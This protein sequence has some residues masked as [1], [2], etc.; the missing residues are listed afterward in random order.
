MHISSALADCGERLWTCDNGDCIPINKRCDGSVDCSDHSDEIAENCIHMASDCLPFGF[1]C[2][3]GACIAG[4]GRCDNNTDC[5]DKSDEYACMNENPEH[6]RGNCRSNQMQCLT[7]KECIG[8]NDMC[9]GVKNCRDG[10]DETVEVCAG[11]D[12]SSGFQ[13]GYGG[14][15]ADYAKCNK[16]RECVDGSDEAWELCGT[17]RKP[18]ISVGVKTI[19]FPDSTAIGNGGQRCRIPFDL[20]SVI[21]LRHL[22]GNSTLKPG[23]FV[24]QLEVVYF[25]CFKNNKKLDL[26]RRKCEGGEFNGP[27]PKCQ[28]VCNPQL[29]EGLSTIYNVYSASGNFVKRSLHRYGIAVGSIIH[30]IC[31]PG[32][33]RQQMIGKR[34]ILRC[35]TDGTFDQKREPCEQY[36]G[37]PSV[38]MASIT[39]GVTSNDPNQVPWHVSIYKLVNNKWEFICGGSIVTPRIVISA[40]HCFWNNELM[41]LEHS[42]NFRFVAGKQQRVFDDIQENQVL[43]RGAEMINASADFEGIRTNNFAD[44][45]VIKLDSPF[46]YN[47]H[48]SAIC[49]KHFT[50]LISDI[51]Q[52]NITGTVTGYNELNNNMERVSMTTQGYYECIQHKSIGETLSEDKF[53]L[54]KDNSERI[55]RGDSGGAFAQKLKVDF[56]KSEDLYYL[57]GIIS[58]TPRTENECSRTGYVAATNAKFMRPDLYNIFLKEINN[59]ESLF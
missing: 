9:N 32:Y 14:C 3:Y 38:P 36:C 6:H 39:K 45:A 2:S 28:V 50:R 37:H 46:V 16:I 48:I 24:E 55:C 41:R 40:A 57:L 29:L 31:A 30:S 44:I 1:V 33:K 54:Y 10:S 11:F 23:D 58:F 20:Q 4:V 7:S 35:L 13:C 8:R 49:F 42:N 53:C 56:P 47:E 34:Q 15:V 51:V 52:S 26:G 43:I 5:A 12:C 59:D 27:I 18:E 25:E 22:T 21:A 19:V 17:P